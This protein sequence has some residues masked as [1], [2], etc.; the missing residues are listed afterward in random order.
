VIEDE[1]RDHTTSAA[2]EQEANTSNLACQPI[3][4]S[5]W[6]QMAKNDKPCIEAFH[7]TRCFLF[8]S[9][10]LRSLVGLFPTRTSI[11]LLFWQY[12]KVRIKQMQ[13][14]CKLRSYLLVVPLEDMPEPRVTLWAKPDP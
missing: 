3:P 4:S 11:D 8:P 14:Q 5:F 2:D 12:R 9:N 7:V 10:T 6:Y 1:T 13:M